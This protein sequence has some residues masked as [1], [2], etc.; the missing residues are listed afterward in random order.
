MKY[1]HL[2]FLNMRYVIYLLTTLLILHCGSG[3]EIE[4]DDEYDP[5]DYQPGID[6]EIQLTFFKDSEAQNPA[7]IKGTNLL[8]FNRSY[9]EEKFEIW[10][11]DLGK[12]T[13]SKLYGADNADVVSMPGSSWNEVVQR[14]C[15]ACDQTSNDEI[16]TIKLDG[17]DLRQ[18]T[19]DPAL[20]WEPTWSPDGQ[21]LTFQSNRSGN[22]EIYKIQS[23]GKNLT[24]LTNH[25]ADDCEPNWSPDGEKIVFQSIRSGKWDIWI[26]DTNGQNLQNITNSQHED[27]DPSWSPDSKYVVFSSDRTGEADIYVINAD[28]TKYLKRVTQHPAYDGAPSWSPDGENIVFESTR[29][30][31]LNLFMVKISK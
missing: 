3:E 23:D 25:S 4:N 5:D 12:L 10:L 1:L 18:I 24:R 26:M 31:K 28:S 8:M 2:K 14:I 21:W 6:S 15:F 30:G 27:T 11:L 9:H 19:E 7:W 22:W 17:T 20:D 13:Y 29:A 16:W